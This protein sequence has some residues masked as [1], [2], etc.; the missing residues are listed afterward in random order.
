[1][2]N[3]NNSH[4]LEWQ[5][6]PGRGQIQAF[7]ASPAFPVLVHYLEFQMGRLAEPLSP[8][9]PGWA[10]LR[11]YQDGGL[12]ALKGLKDYLENLA[13]EKKQQ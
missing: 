13:R 8:T 6:E 7:L 10:V 11:A 1:M 5:V 9:E 12:S 2:L 3:N 4:K